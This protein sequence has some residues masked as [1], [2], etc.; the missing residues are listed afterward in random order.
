[1][2]PGRFLAVPSGVWAGIAGIIQSNPAFQAIDRETL[3]RLSDRSGKADKLG[4]V[5]DLLLDGAAETAGT[6]PIPLPAE[7]I[8][9]VCKILLKKTAER[10]TK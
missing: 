9:R 8:K 10:S 6:L 1:L 2:K 7:T 5:A 3:L 4:A